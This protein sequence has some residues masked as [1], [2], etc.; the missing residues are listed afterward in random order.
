MTRTVPLPRSEPRAAA[1]D[2][3]EM[4]DVARLK[5]NPLNPRSEVSESD[6]RVIE[7]A[8]SIKETKGPIEPLLVLPDGSIV[9]GER[10]WVACRIAGI[11]RTRV[12]VRQ[13][14]EQEQ[15]VVMMAENVQRESLNLIE[16]A[17]G[18]QRLKDT[19]L[20]QTEIARRT[21]VPAVR[22]SERLKLLSFPEDVQALFKDNQIPAGAAG[23]LSELSNFEDK[24]RI[25][26]LIVSRRLSVP[27]LKK[28]VESELGHKRKKSLSYGRKESPS[29]ERPKGVIRDQLV[30]ALRAKTQETV[31]VE[32]LLGEMDF[33]CCACG[34]ADTPQSQATLCAACPL[35]AFLN[36][37]AGIEVA[38]LPKT[39][40]LA[41]TCPQ[42]AH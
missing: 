37:F 34:M 33:V 16:E 21:G 31:T 17:T 19:G 20:Q 2:V 30:A 29:K 25:A 4:R 32:R 24:T 15:L 22:V 41:Q 1:V 9:A 11:K 39:E 42:G 28:L 26:C 40:L 36:R 23:P 5:R 8:N 10:R 13:M 7:L 38:G 18:Y 35:A 3:V 14:S 6:A 27:A 12:I